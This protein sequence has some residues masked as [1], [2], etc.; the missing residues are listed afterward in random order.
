MNELL[1]ALIDCGVPVPVIGFELGEE[2]WNA[3]M[4]WPDR[5]VAVLL[6]GADDDPE[7]M[8]RNEAFEAAGWAARTASEWTADELAERLK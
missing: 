2:A 1:R 8:K 4:A 6:A 5:R 3:E 7:I